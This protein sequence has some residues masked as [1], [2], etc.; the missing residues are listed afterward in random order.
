MK[1]SFTSYLKN[2]TRIRGNLLKKVSQILVFL[3]LIIFHLNL[4]AQDKTVTGIVTEAS[5]EA[6]PGV[7][8]RIQGTQTVATTINNGKFSIKIPK[9]VAKPIL[10]VSYIGYVTQQIE[11]GPRTNLTIVLKESSSSLTD[12]VV[13]GYGTSRKKDLTGAVG[14]VKMEDINKAPVY[15]LD[16]ALAGRVAGVQVTSPD[17]QPGA[18]SEILIRGT[19]SITSSA[20]PLYVVDGFPQEDNAFNSI[21]PSDVESITILKDASS[22]A[23]YGARGANGV[24]VITTKRGQAGTPNISFKGYAG[25]QDIL[26]K[27]ELLNA[28]DFVRLQQDISPGYARG[29]YFTEGK[30]LESYRNVETVDWQDKVFQAAPFQN[31]SLTMSGRSGET[32]YYIS[33][34]YVDQTGLVIASGFKRYQGRMTLDQNLG[35]KFK[36]GLVANYAAT[37]AFG[38]QTSTQ[39]QGIGSGTQNSPQFNLLQNVWSYRPINSSGNL[40]ALENSFQDDEAGDRD[41]DRLNPYLLALNTVNNNNVNNLQTNGYV[42]YR[43]L[44]DLKLRSTV[45]ITYNTGRTEFFN[46]TFTRGGSPLTGQ[47]ATNGMSGGINSSNSYSFLNENTLTYDKKIGK[48]HTI[49]ALVGFTNQRNKFK[50]SSFSAI[51]V[52]NEKLGISG[53]DEGTPFSVGSSSSENTLASFLG[54]VNYVYK[55]RYL[56][57]ASIRADGSSKFYEGHKWGYFPTGAVAWKITGEDFMK[58]LKAISTAKLRASYGVTGNNRVS[59]YAYSSPVQLSGSSTTTRYSFNGIIT[60]GAIPTKMFN[61]NLKWETSRMLDLGLEI[62]VLKDRFY[63]E[64]DYYKKKTY[65]LLLTSNIPSSLGFNT[66]VENIGDIQNDGLE[67]SLNTTNIKTTNFIWSTNLNIS[68]NKN[69]VLSLSRNQ[70]VREELSASSTFGTDYASQ[71]LYIAKL[72]Q[73][74]AQFFGYVYDG[75][76]RL[77]DFD[78]IRNGTETTYRLKSTVPYPGTNPVSVKPGDV[79]FRDLNNDGLINEND[80]AVIGNPYAKHI[81]GISNNFTYKAFDLNVFLQW[82]YG[83]QVYNGNRTVNE[84]QSTGDTRGL[85]LNMFASYAD[86]YTLQND[87][88]QYP[89]ANANA[90]GIRSF[91]SRFVEDASFLRLKTV[92]LGYSF[93]QKLLKKIKVT[94][95]RLYISGQNLY[96]WTKYT[97]PDPE[98]STKNSPTTPG[99]DF[100]PYP[101]TRVIVFGLN[102]TL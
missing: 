17:G 92:S 21:N 56:L 101:R 33:G 6:I 74:V 82:S 75:L 94:N 25:T 12:V 11:L 29:V 30:T 9:E 93:D 96:T 7:S 54:R 73:Q 86:Y 77:A 81:G 84:G 3:L 58:N 2:L 85:G 72:G 20:G 13:V 18:A 32:N 37:K 63:L 14:V 51:Q 97:G 19:G 61:P 52:P 50:A 66:T 95:A 90:F 31:Y 53:L 40:D 35:K 23:I 88:G 89:G 78:V 80:Y 41:L 34:N 15:S 28:Y 91:S 62:G 47:G 69:K 26:K 42:E 57:T 67:F 49:N 79:K 27:M 43:F 24:V 98:V 70:Q 99:F 87:D 46:N 8:I 36:V 102:V 64:V 10:V 39:S 83:N 55:D 4:F 22:T 44:K 76:Y 45:G 68:F 38:N 71:P 16:Q 65:D 48:D 5:G 59:D 60:N 100:S 1:K